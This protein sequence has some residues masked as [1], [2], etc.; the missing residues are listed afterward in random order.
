MAKPYKKNHF[1][2]VVYQKAWCSENDE[3]IVLNTKDRLIRT[4]APKDIA[5]KKNLY[6]LPTTFKTETPK[7]TENII[8]KVWEDRW[9]PVIE[10]IHKE[11]I[12]KGDT[13]RDLKGFVIVQSFR[14]PKFQKENE[15]VMNMLPKDKHV[16]FK[17]Q[18]A[19]LGIKGFTEYIKYSNCKI[20]KATGLKNFITTDNPSTHWLENGTNITYLNYIMLRHELFQNL[21]YLLICPISPRYCAI[22]YPNLGLERN[23]TSDHAPYEKGDDDRVARFNKLIEHGADK[24]LMVKSI[25]D[26]V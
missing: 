14:T 13:L 21:N 8:F 15:R 18:F 24:L 17:L 10:K 22:V 9:N 6:T 5:K 2:P 4:Q 12:I 11:E 3:V 7:I 26:L 25:S 19:F 1:V 23:K 20:V 16:D